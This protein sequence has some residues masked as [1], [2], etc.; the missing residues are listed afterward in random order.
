MSRH[1]FEIRLQGDTLSPD[2]VRAHELGALMA[3]VEQM[4]AAIV[5]RDNPS[6]ALEDAQVV[7][8]LAGLELGSYTLRFQTPY[9][10]ETVLAYHQIAQAIQT[11][12]YDDLPQKTID[13]LKEARQISRRLRTDIEFWEKPPHTTEY[14]SIAVIAAN[15]AIEVTAKEIEGFA[16]VYGTVVR[17][18]GVN[19]PRVTLQLLDETTFSCNLSEKESGIK[20][21]QQLGS[22]LYRRVGVRG[23]A[24]WRVPTMDLVFFRIEELLDYEGQK[25]LQENLRAMRDVIGD[26]YDDLDIQG[27]ISELRDNGGEVEA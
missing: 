26:W 25:P 10:K 3:A 15:T 20:I 13:A 24:R 7:I 22:R 9:E 19:P 21:A 5:A 1:I 23:M 18:G 14:Q 16:T 4:V 2:T 8:G 12:L 11:T 27:L 6:L 17:V